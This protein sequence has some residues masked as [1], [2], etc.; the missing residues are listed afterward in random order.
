MLITVSIALLLGKN[1]KENSVDAEH[2]STRLTICIPLPSGRGFKPVSSVL[3][4][5]TSS[6]RRIIILHNDGFG[7][8]LYFT[9]GQQNQEKVTLSIPGITTEG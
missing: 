1:K 2:L 6:P 5:I 4:V 8:H 9:G 3:G 7:V